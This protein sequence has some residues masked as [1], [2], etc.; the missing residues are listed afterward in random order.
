MGLFC[1]FNMRLC[2]S[3]ITL[4]VYLLYYILSKYFFN[5]IKDLLLKH[6]LICEIMIFKV[7]NIYILNICKKMICTLILKINNNNVPFY[8]VLL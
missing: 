7:C 3:K 2:T 6:T 4:V 5:I 1:L 8:I